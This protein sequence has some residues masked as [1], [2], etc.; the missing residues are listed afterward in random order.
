MA[1]TLV[2]DANV[3][4]QINRGNTDAANAL[5]RMIDGGDT[6]Y[7]SS[8]AY[9]ELVE[10]PDIPRTATANR[11]FLLNLKINQAPAGSAATRLDVYGKNEPGRTSIMSVEDVL[12]AAQAKA[13][14]AEVFSL[15]RAYR[16]NGNAIQK[17]MNVRIAPETTGVGLVDR[18][19][20]DYR[21]GRRLMGL[22][23]IEV[24]LNGNIIRNNANAATHGGID[25][26]PSS[27][28][29]EQQ[30]RGQAI[31]GGVMLAFEGINFILN[32]INDSIQKKAVENAL[33]SV[34]AQVDRDRSA[35]PKEGVLL[36]FFYKTIDAGDSLIRP[37][38][39]FDYLDYGLGVTRDEA[40]QDM[41]KFGTISS[42]LRSDEKRTAEEIWIAPLIASTVTEA[43]CPFPAYAIGRFYTGTGTKAR[44]QKVKF[45]WIEGFDDIVED[46][47]DLG[48]PDVNYEFAVL[49][50]PA[51]V[52]WYN[53]NG[54]QLVDVPRVSR[55]TANGNWIDVVDLDTGVPFA[56]AC[57]AM[58]FPTTQATEQFFNLT[59]ATE[60]GGLLRTYT[61]FSMIR[62][63]RPQY[64]HLLR[65]L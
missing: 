65:F 62:W 15:D 27:V 43:R 28:L 61:N 21:V 12:T 14:D 11:E 57:A 19:T 18:G 52:R 42:G 10:Q 56:H 55:Q 20:Q 32:K 22:P 25:P 5:K 30:M 46:S 40:R 23:P 54:A 1:R 41:N 60:D 53:M 3:V 9:K 2:I 63:I 34:R 7:V 6:V 50:M 59:T 8:Q 49:K 24:G 45:D 33:D 13:I 64:L 4:D 48:G 26:L 31:G 51:Q 39:V 35:N 58:V 36:S 37:G 38:P 17:V 16:N 44:F 47:V 29:E